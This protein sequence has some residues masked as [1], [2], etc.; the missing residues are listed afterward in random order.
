MTKKKHLI[1]VIMISLVLVGCKTTEKVSEKS[2]PPVNDKVNLKKASSFNVQLGLGYLKQGN[3]TRAK[4]KLVTAL[5]QTP[6]SAQAVG[7][8][9]YFFETT[10]QYKKAESYYHKAMKLAPKQGAEINNYGAFLCRQGRYK[11]AD[12]YF[13]KAIN[14]IDY[15]NSPAALENAGLCALE[16]PNMALA[17]SYFSQALQQDPHRTESLRQLVKIDLKKGKLDTAVQLVAHYKKFTK[18]KRAIAGIEQEIA[19]FKQ[20]QLIDVA[21]LKGVEH[22]DKQQ[23][24]IG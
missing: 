13:Q 12:K 8:M 19:K 23:N 21:H 5:K 17:E 6:N 2:P 14:D 11:L 16:I 4:R 15:V 22:H 9:A 3:M 10:G 7:A 24:G 20:P 1:Q 18:S